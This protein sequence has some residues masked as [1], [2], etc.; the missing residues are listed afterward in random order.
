MSLYSARSGGEV[1][2]EAVV[3]VE[4][5]DEGVSWIGETYFAEGMLIGGCWVKASS[6]ESSRCRAMSSVSK[7]WLA[8]LRP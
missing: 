7:T 8:C 5:D 1:E 3:D 4:I 2:V 6:Y